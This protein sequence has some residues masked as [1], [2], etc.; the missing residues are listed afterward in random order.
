ME[1]SGTNIPKKE[2]K[3]KERKEKKKRSFE[4]VHIPNVTLVLGRCYR[5]KQMI[6]ASGRPSN[7]LDPRGTGK[8]DFLGRSPTS[9]G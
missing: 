8:Q 5:S 7:F 4:Y 2:E 3:L 9:R 1:V 6:M